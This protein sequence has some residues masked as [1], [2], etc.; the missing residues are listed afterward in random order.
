MPRTGRGGKREGAP[1]QAYANRTD[2]N[3]RGPE[4]I[5]VAPGQAY[6]EGKMQAD[7]QRAVPMGGTPSP[8]MGSTPP[9][10]MGA[11]QAPAIPPSAPPMPEPGERLLTAPTERPDEH[12]TTGLYSDPQPGQPAQKLSDVLMQAADSPFATNNI[13]AL[14]KF[15]KNFNL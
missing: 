5:T 1:G 11:P 7:A 4:P 13:L 2:L 10:S 8:P 9:P 12:V 15:A 6:G 14:A 3:K